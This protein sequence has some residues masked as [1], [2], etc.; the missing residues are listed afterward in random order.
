MHERASDSATRGGVVRE[1]VLAQLWPG[2]PRP[3]PTS[4]KADGQDAPTSPKA[5]GSVLDQDGV[6]PIDGD[7][8]QDKVAQAKTGESYG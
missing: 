8:S 7:G 4:T 1:T 2:S 3:V 5:D 6:A